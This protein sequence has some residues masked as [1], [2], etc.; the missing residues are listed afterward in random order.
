MQQSNNFHRRIRRFDYDAADV[1]GRCVGESVARSPIDRVFQPDSFQESLRIP[2]NPFKSSTTSG[3][4]FS[5]RSDAAD[6]NDA[7][8]ATVKNGQKWKYGK[9]LTKNQTENGHN[10]VK[11]CHNFTK[12]ITKISTKIGL[13]FDQIW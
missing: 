7:T 8:D 12:K 5:I 3:Q 1:T 13:K 2:K 10:L 11:H 9:I 6:R 4:T